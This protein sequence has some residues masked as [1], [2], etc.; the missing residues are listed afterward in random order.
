VSTLIGG[1]GVD[2]VHVAHNMDKWWVLAN[3]T[4]TAVSINWGEYFDY[5]LSEESKFHNVVSVYWA[6][7]RY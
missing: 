7:V 1:R 3:T 6:K 4:G 5:L 2:W